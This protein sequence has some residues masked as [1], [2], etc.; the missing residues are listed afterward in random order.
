[1]KVLVLVL[2]LF[3]FT[4]SFCQKKF[5]NL[6]PTKENILLVCEYH[7]ILFPKY[8]LAQAIQESGLKLKTHNN[9]FG[10]KYTKGL[11]RFSH[12]SYS[13]K[14]YKEKIQSRYK[15]GESYLGFLKRIK[16]ARDPNY[17]NSLKRIVNTL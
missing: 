13:V 12:W 1:M 3:T 10:L 8:V 16:Y 9:L 14:A 17:I 15:Q 4:S 5:E 2:F 11:Y 6:P 7:Q